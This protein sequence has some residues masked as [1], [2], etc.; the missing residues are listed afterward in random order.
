MWKAAWS[1]ADVSH[2]SSHTA[3]TKKM[4]NLSASLLLSAARSPLT[5]FSTQCRY[6][7]PSLTCHW[8]PACVLIMFLQ[9]ICRLL[10]A[11]VAALGAPHCGRASRDVALSA[12]ESLLQHQEAAEATEAAE[13]ADAGDSETFAAVLAPH[14]PA[15]LAALRAVVLA[16]TG[17]GGKVRGFLT[18]LRIRV[19]C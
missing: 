12:V 4:C 18:A 17:G 6:V 11:V 14:A 7:S 15:L 9:L 8:Y 1:S 3:A 16:A 19:S 2:A 5:R 10:A 13:E